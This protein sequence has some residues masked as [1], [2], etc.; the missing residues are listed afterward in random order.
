MLILNKKQ[1]EESVSILDVLKAV[2]KAFLLQESGDFLMPRRMHVEHNGNVLLLMP[3]FAG[4][5]FA[6]KLVSVFPE[7]KNMDLPAIYGTVILNDGKTGKPLAMMDGS[8]VTAWRTGAVGGLG[9]AYTTPKNISTLGLIGA[10]YQGLHQVLFAA[11]VRNINT[12]NFYEPHEKN[13]EHFV[14]NLRK[15]LPH[16]QLKRQSDPAQVLASSEVIV[17]ATTSETPVVPHDAELLKNRHFIGIGSYKPS[18]REYP[19]ALFR[20]TEKV[21]VDTPHAHEETSDLAVPLKKGLL[22]K[23][24]ILTLGKLISGK[25][26]PDTSGTTFFK[27]VGMALF[28][29]LTAETIYKKAREK[30]TGTEIEF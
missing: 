4:E 1:I 5:Y 11:V 25:E 3:A 13:A 6:T 27:S 28:D 18:M 20:L 10:G 24:R 26:T 23:D 22:P 14:A 29:L 9:I 30:Q 17:T 15:Y 21:I 16:I 12:V 8:T 19:D 2:E 7:N